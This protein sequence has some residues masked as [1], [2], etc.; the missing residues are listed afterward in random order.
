MRVARRLTIGK[1]AAASGVNLETI[2]YYERIGLMPA[3][4]RT[5]SGHRLYEDDHRRRLTFIRRGREL[6]FSLE[7]IRAL[8][9]LAEPQ[10]RSCDEVQKIAAAH[11]DEVRG[12]IADLVGLEALL[13]ETVRRCGGETDAPAC[14]VLDL[15]EG[16]AA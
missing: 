3:P 15:L 16:D 11:L 4:D 1:L 2:R 6:G 5:E 14:A 9:A 10:R 7:E 13:A 8:L 12:K